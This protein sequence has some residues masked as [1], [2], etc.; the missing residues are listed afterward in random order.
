[1]N[2]IEQYSQLIRKYL[3][4][5]ASKEERAQLQ[6][7]MDDPVFL[8]VWEKV[9]RENSY[10]VQPAAYPDPHRMLENILADPR[11]ATSASTPQRTTDGHFN[12]RRNWWQVAAVFLALCGAV[13]WGYYNFY[14]EETQPKEQLSKVSIVPGSDKAM[15]ILEDG[16]QIDL[17]LLRADTVLDQG[18]YLITK[19]NKGQ[20]SYRLKDSR[21]QAS[22]VVYN[23]IITPRGGEY[24][25]RMADG[26]LVQ[27][28]AGSKIKYP[29]K[30]DAKLRSVQ[31]EGEAYF[32]VA[33]MDVKGKRVPFIVQS[34]GQTLEVLGTHFNIKSFG[35]HIVTTL[36]EGKVKLSFADAALKEQVLAPNDQVVFD[37]SRR[38]VKKEQVDPFYSLAWK[39]GNFAFDNASI[40]TVMDEVARWYDVEISYG[41]KL[42]GQHFSGTISRYENIDKLLKT[43]A[44]AGGVHFERKGRRIYVLN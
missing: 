2:Q 33:K 42:Q 36:V 11:I 9:W 28:N 3:A 39:N 30:F 34:G 18:E 14:T 40:Q 35:D 38:N 24:T 20:I 43:I 26:S 37:K 32:E 27:L 5:Q 17:S 6:E 21:S 22:S 1:M 19:D 16:K 12:F 29:V 13:L 7:L 25:L 23:T 10:P 4:D 44:F 41:D 31:L 8:Q 15:I